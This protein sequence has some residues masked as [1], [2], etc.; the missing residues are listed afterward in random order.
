VLARKSTNR[1]NQE[2]DVCVW[3]PSVVTP[4]SWNDI[5]VSKNVEDS[6]LRR[7][8]VGIEFNVKEMISKKSR[9]ER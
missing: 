7:S 2:L 3:N 9:V 4:L 8:L 6:Y 1:R 5:R